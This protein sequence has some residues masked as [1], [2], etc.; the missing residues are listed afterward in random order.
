MPKPWQSEAAKKAWKTRSKNR[1]YHVFYKYGKPPVHGSTIKEA[2][3][4]KVARQKVEKELKR[5]NGKVTR[6]VPL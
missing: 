4:G 6:V 1:K 5:F 2:R 3:N